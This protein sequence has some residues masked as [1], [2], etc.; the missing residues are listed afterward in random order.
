MCSTV[1]LYD[2]LLFCVSYSV[3]SA[4]ILQDLHYTEEIDS[5]PMVYTDDD[6]ND[7]DYQEEK[8][9]DIGSDDTDHGRVRTWIVQMSVYV[10][11]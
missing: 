2:M 9:K 10:L 1:T 6:D 7:P 4:F 8:D 11:V 5:D 3:W